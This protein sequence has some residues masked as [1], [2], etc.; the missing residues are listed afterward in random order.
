MGGVFFNDWQTGIIPRMRAAL[1]PQC[2]TGSHIEPAEPQATASI[3]RPERHLVTISITAIAARCRT[4]VAAYSGT[5]SLAAAYRGKRH[6]SL[7]PGHGCLMMKNCKLTLILALFAV[8]LSGCGWVDSIGVQNGDVVA[9]S[10][11][12]TNTTGVVNLPTINNSTST[13]NTSGIGGVIVDGGVVSLNEQSTQR[14]VLSDSPDTSAAWAW[15]LTD[16]SDAIQQCQLIDG[17]DTE[18]STQQLQEACSSETNCSF[19]VQE[20]REQGNTE[21]NITLPELKAPVALSFLLETTLD[22]GERHTQEQ[23]VCGIAINEAPDVANDF[24]LAVTSATRVVE[25]GSPFTLLANDSDDE[26]VRN[27]P[28]FVKEINRT[29]A[30]ATSLSVTR[31]GAFRYV[32]Q[33]NL[34]LGDNEHLDDTIGIVISDGVHDVNSEITIRVVNVNTSP[35]LISQIP[36][37]S[38]LVSNENTANVNIDLSGF[39]ID[40]EGDTLSYRAASSPFIESGDLNLS[41]DGLLQGTL[42]GNDVGSHSFTIFVYDG[43]HEVNAS[44]QI[45]VL[46]NNPINNDPEVTDIPNRTVSGSIVYDVAPFFSDPD[47]DTLS[48][49]SANLPPGLQISDSGVIT[50]TATSANDGRWL[51]RVTASD[52][53]GG[54]V[55]DQFRMTIDD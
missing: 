5:S 29:P 11:N 44:F 47:G 40:A 34:G 1:E 35:A 53:R 22:S 2:Q 7:I 21:F 36:D 38:T 17:F 12:S 50:G 28:L 49:S 4:A 46:D 52:N 54:T 15:R 45:N 13:T 18:V 41:P 23:T 16:R 9:E 39:F 33:Q 3:H 30:F 43:L 31:D 55:S 32:P 42:S 25:A 24:Y 8:P 27:L 14:F 6:H 48:F 20:I 37:F 26:H 10:D 19:A 51:I